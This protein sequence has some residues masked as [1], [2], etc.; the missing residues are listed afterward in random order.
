MAGDTNEDFVPAIADAL[1]AS[2]F[3]RSEVEQAARRQIDVLREWLQERPFG[4]RADNK[5]Y[6]KEVESLARQLQQK[7]EGAPEGTRRILFTFAFYGR[8]V[9][10]P[11]NVNHV[12]VEKYRKEC[13]ARLKRIRTGCAVISAEPVGDYH[14]VDVTK[15]LCAGA[16]FSLMI[17]V[18]AGRP[19]N[20][21]PLRV[22]ANLLFE[23]V[24]PDRVEEW[25]EHHRGEAPDLRRQC[26]EVLKHQRGRSK[27]DLEHE[28]EELLRLWG[29]HE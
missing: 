4:G 15:G 11:E 10:R 6:A 12:A 16:A 25:R 3:S 8:K 2:P 19:T 13:L 5:Q 17:G 1:Q 23:A 26:Q 18:D 24:A 27:A 22:I 21:D 20:G 9:P 7:L 29:L 14:T 28:R